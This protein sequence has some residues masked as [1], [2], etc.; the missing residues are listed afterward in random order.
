M[1]ATSTR[2]THLPP[3]KKQVMLKKLFDLTHVPADQKESLISVLKGNIDVF[4]DE[5]LWTDSNSHDGNGHQHPRSSAHQAETF[6]TET[7]VRRP[8]KSNAESWDYSAKQL[9][10]VI[11]SHC[12]SQKRWFPKNLY[13][14][15]KIKRNHCDPRPK[16][17]ER[18]RHSILAGKIKVQN[19]PGSKAGFWQVPI[20]EED[21]EKAA[22]GTD[23]GIF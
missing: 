8:H 21:K 5:R 4:F 2:S 13:R 22:F 10:M 6:S 20:R 12:R 7:G 3:P 14:F 18:R 1:S 15:Q 23:A 19:E 17:P 16:H 11:S 9:A